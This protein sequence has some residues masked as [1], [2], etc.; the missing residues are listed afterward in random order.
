ASGC[1]TFTS[2]ASNA[3][4][5][6][7]GSAISGSPYVTGANMNAGS[8]VDYSAPNPSVGDQLGRV[9]LAVAPSDPNVIYAQVQSIA[10]N[11]AGCG[12]APGCQLGVW[13]TND[14][15]TNW[16]FMQGS[17]G[18]ALDNDPCGFDY[19]Q[20]WYDQGLAVDPNNADKLMVD[21]YDVWRATRT[22]TALTD[23]T[24]GYFGTGAHPVHVDQHALAYVPGSSDIL[25]VGSDGGAFATTSAS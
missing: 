4:G 15:G 23:L 12:G 7:Y 6:V 22:G 14:G 10:P 8:G 13:Q 21:T 19:P 18:P 3:N 25:L 11:T 2:I 5:F 16:H 20:N 24:C 1:P 17:Q 9:E